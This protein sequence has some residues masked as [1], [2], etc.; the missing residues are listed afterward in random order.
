MNDDYE[1]AVREFID[2]IN[3]QVG[4]YMDAL[5]GFSGHHTRVERQIHRVNRPERVRQN[6][7]RVST[8]VWASYED[9]SQPEI[10]HNRIIR[11]DEYLAANAPGGSN[12]NRHAKAIL[13]FLYTFWE[14]EVRPRLAAAKS[15]EASDVKADIMGDIRLLRNSIL[16]RKSVLRR[17]MFEQLTVTKDL[18]TVDQEIVLSYE[19]MHR[20][21]VLAKQHCAR[22]LLDHLGIKDG[23]VVP[24][25]I[26]DIAVQQRDRMNNA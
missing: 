11:A 20:L 24:E 21:F 1:K 19:V 26:V 23:P 7:D 5:A 18:F 17:D 9:P 6:P 8:V 10:I 22:L 14:L 25:K 13:V 15:A 16:H 3:A 4:A 12:E 2:F